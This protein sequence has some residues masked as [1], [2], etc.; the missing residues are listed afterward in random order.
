MGLSVRERQLALRTMTALG[1][2]ESAKTAMLS[3]THAPIGKGGR[4]WI[5]RTAPGNAGQ[6]PAYIQ[7]VR[8]AI[9]RDDKDL[10]ESKATKIAIGRI[11]D[12][13]ASQGKVSPEVRKAAA[14]AI[15]E[16]EKLRAKSHAMTAAGKAV[17]EAAVTV[18]LEAKSD[19]DQDHPTVFCVKDRAKVKPTTDGKCP[20][21]GSD[22]SKAIDQAKKVQEAVL[23]STYAEALHPRGRGGQ[24]TAKQ[25]SSGQEVKGIQSKVGAKTDGKFGGLT[26]RAVMRYQRRHGLQI[27]GVVGAQTV[28]AMMGKR[29]AA[30]VKVGAMS[31]ADRRWL[32]GLRSG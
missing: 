1:V 11:K 14:K 29:R 8:N 27:D 4:N 24:W 30:Q 25:G 20:K 32:A 23:E 26:R 17:K 15:A 21:C 3:V 7:N 2:S 19:A 12:W 10:D 6:L 31:A 18:I 22:L 16:W 13:A 5:T 28:A 9:M